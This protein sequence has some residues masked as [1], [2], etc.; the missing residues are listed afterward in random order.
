ME[1]TAYERIYAAVRSIP[2]G[3][4]SSYGQAAKA[5]GYFRGARMVG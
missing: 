4:V 3:K 2:Y 5:A 1:S